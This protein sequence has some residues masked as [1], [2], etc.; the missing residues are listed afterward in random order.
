MHEQF[1]VGLM[2]LLFVYLWAGQISEE[3]ERRMGM[4]D[5]L[6]NRFGMILDSVQSDLMQVNRGTKEL[7]LESEYSYLILGNSVAER[8]TFD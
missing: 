3:L 1:Y 4:M 6:L 8:Q 5:T 2:L 7:S